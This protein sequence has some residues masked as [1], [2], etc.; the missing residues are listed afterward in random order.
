[1]LLNLDVYFSSGPTGENSR[2]LTKSK[3]YVMVVQW[4]PLARYNQKDV[5]WLKPSLLLQWYIT[6]FCLYV[7][8]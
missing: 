6:I 2:V 5:I 3:A 1:M 8:H 7:I 4:L